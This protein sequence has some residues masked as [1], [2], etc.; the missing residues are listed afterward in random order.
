LATPSPLRPSFRYPINES[1]LENIWDSG[2]Y[3]KFFHYT[4]GQHDGQQD[5]QFGHSDRTDF[6]EE[7]RACGEAQINNC[8]LTRSN[9]LIKLTHFTSSK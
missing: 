4:N 2:K 1:P 3:V 8:T 7:R 9:N 5:Q 6:P